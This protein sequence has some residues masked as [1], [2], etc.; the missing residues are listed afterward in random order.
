MRGNMLLQNR[1]SS[2]QRHGLCHLNSCRII[3]LGNLIY[4]AVQLVPSDSSK[5][6]SL[7]NA[8]STINAYLHMEAEQSTH[9][10]C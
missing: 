2:L 3:Y 7:S 6:S 9:R 8:H 1:V 4:A 10:V 5:N